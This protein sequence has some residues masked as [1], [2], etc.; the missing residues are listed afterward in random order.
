MKE[1]REEN[2]ILKVSVDGILHGKSQRDFENDIQQEKDRVTDYMQINS[3]IPKEYNECK[4]QLKK[5]TDA[6]KRL[7]RERVIEHLK[8]SEEVEQLKSNAIS[9]WR[10]RLSKS[11]VI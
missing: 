6:N 9:L 1:T 8:F 3:E 7:E 4:V 10:G 11:I 2:G 5:F